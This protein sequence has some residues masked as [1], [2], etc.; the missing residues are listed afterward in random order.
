MGCTYRQKQRTRNEGR[1]L[2]RAEAVPLR[3]DVIQ[4]PAYSQWHSIIR[5][6]YAPASDRIQHAVH[7]EPL[8]FFG[9]RLH[10]D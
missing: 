4:P 5:V 2:E 10:C 7:H 6:Q 9:G 1:R 3:A 8:P